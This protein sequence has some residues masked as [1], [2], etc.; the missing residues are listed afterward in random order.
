VRS[1][2]GQASIEVVALVGLVAATFTAIVAFVP[3][4]DGRPLGSLIAHRVVCAV[5]GRCA[6][7]DRA[8]VRAYGARDAAMVRDKLQGL[9]F[10]PGERQLPVDW[11]VCRSVGCATVQGDGSGDAHRTDAGLAATAFTRVQRHAGRLHIQYWFYYPD[12]NTAWGGSDW[13]W[14]HSPGLQRIGLLLRGTST[15]PGFHRDDWESAAIRVD[16]DGRSEV[17]VTSHG[18][19]QSC[20]SGCESQWG[21]PSGWT[22]VSRGSHAGHVPR[23]RDP[24]ERTAAADGIRLVPLETIDRRR[25]RRLAPQIAPPWSKEAY[26]DPESSAS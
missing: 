18:L 1:E 14:R 22:R 11:R 20:K 13:L 9:V 2:D 19:W 15:Y 10:E 17:R 16:A 3:A 25:Y 8:L 4:V 23:A 26:R 24:D 12:S 5:S 7:E 21:T 6:N